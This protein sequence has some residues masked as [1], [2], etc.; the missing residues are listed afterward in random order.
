VT[1]GSIVDRFPG[2]IGQPHTSVLFGDRVD[3]GD[4]FGGR[5]AAGYWLSKDHMLGVDAG[6]FF[7][8]RQSVQFGA[9]SQLGSPILAVPFFDV[10][11]NREGSSVL[12][13]P[14][15]SSGAVAASLASRLWGYDL[16]ARS[17]LLHGEGYSASALVGFRHLELSEGLDLGIS[18]V[19][20]SP[21]PFLGSASLASS[22]T[23]HTRNYF[24]GPQLGA[25]VSACRG[26]VAVHLIAKVAL[27][28]VHEVADINGTT[29]TR[30]FTGATSTIPVALFAQN[31][32][33]GRHTRDEFA[34]VP[35]ISVNVGYN[36]TRNIRATLGYSFLYLSSAM[37]PGDAIDRGINTSAIPTPLGTTNLVGPARP[38]FPNKDSEFWAQGISFGI[39][40]Q[41]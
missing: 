4:Q 23:F 7:L 3:N 25:D 37:R 39:R 2:A 22:Q 10:R 28:D 11:N 24:Y 21:L 35:E 9:A 15:I 6:M 41:Y 18:E 33:S 26:P 17:E 40:V 32:N 13:V 8:S 36:V 16:N 1:T 12:S 5:F 38:L 29:T 27:G 20:P 34:V 30:A 19:I 31:S 14:G